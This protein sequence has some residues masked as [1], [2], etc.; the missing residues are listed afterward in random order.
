MQLESPPRSQKL[1]LVPTT[2]VDMA[3]RT[4]GCQSVPTQKHRRNEG[5]ISTLIMSNS[6]GKSKLN[7]RK[8][9][10]M[11]EIEYIFMHTVYSGNFEDSLMEDEESVLV[12]SP[13]GYGTPGMRPREEVGNTKTT[14][15]MAKIVEDV[16]T[17]DSVIRQ[18]TFVYNGSADSSGCSSNNSSPQKFGTVRKVKPYESFEFPVATPSPIGS[19]G[20]LDASSC[21]SYARFSLSM[22]CDSPAK[23]LAVDLACA[24]NTLP[25][26][27]LNCE[28]C[29]KQFISEK[30]LADHSGF[31]SNAA[32]AHRRSEEASTTATPDLMPPFA[33]QSPDLPMY[34]QR[35]AVRAAPINV[36]PLPMSPPCSPSMLKSSSPNACFD[37]FEDEISTFLD[38]LKS[39]IVGPPLVLTQRQQS[40]ASRKGTMGRVQSETSLFDV[41]SDEADNP[42]LTLV[43]VGRQSSPGLFRQQP[44]P[45]LPSPIAMAAPSPPQLMSLTSNNVSV[46]SPIPE[47]SSY[48]FQDASMSTSF[49]AGGLSNFAVANFAVANFG[50]SPVRENCANENGAFVHENRT[51]ASLSMDSAVGVVD[52]NEAPVHEI[53]PTSTLVHENRSTV[54]SSVSSFVGAN[55]V[56]SSIGS[57]T[58]TLMGKNFLPQDDQLSSSL[59]VRYPCSNCGRR[60]ASVLR[61]AKHESVCLGTRRRDRLEDFQN[62][63]RHC[64]RK[65][66]HF[67]Q[68]SRHVCKASL[69][70]E[71]RLGQLCVESGLARVHINVYMQRDVETKLGVVSIAREK[72]HF[73]VQTF[74]GVCFSV[75]R[76]LCVEKF[77][78]FA[79]SSVYIG[80]NVGTQS[81]LVAEPVRVPPVEYGGR[82]DLETSICAYPHS[83][84]ESTSSEQTVRCSTSLEFQYNLLREQIRTCSDRLRSR[85]SVTSR[86]G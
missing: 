38:C 56:S 10:G 41:S 50:L 64:G 14:K 72:P 23:P 78:H 20:G 34:M 69:R 35:A 37:E 3:R 46:N 16:G 55:G 5:N 49:L 31:C 73:G 79:G 26:M 4:S 53:R 62:V 71:T 6:S 66:E 30:H 11:R 9:N 19:S 8:F 18:L 13:F 36:P 75:K 83:L 47:R 33:D 63:C 84:R 52:A 57:S 54:S 32:A 1:V 85:R 67:D 80:I 42:V 76:R 70:Q 39:D 86:D 7:P 48:D 17:P 2:P 43:P 29:G 25:D 68:F 60:F 59:S 40:W 74:A 28:C 82:S 51:T 15:A 61:Q 77:R 21:D 65:F 12:A 24:V 27:L 44:S 22:V 45:P 81:N 58:V